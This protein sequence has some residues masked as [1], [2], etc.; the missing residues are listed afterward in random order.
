MLRLNMKIC[1]GKP[2]K[3]IFY[4]LMN[5]IDCNIHTL[6]WTGKTLRS[7]TQF[8]STSLVYAQADE[9][10]LSIS[11]KENPMILWKSPQ[12]RTTVMILSNTG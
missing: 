9:M 2:Q 5:K 6:E 12:D 1:H 10:L 7:S 3:I 11:T 8:P 4:T